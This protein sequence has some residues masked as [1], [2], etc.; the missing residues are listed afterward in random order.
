[1]KLLYKE[2]ALLQSKATADSRGTATT[3]S[4]ANI[5]AEWI[6]AERIRRMKLQ[7]RWK[8]VANDIADLLINYFTK[9]AD[10]LSDQVQNN[11]LSRIKLQISS[12]CNYKIWLPQT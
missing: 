3:K 10:S 7:I 6:M 11:T 4:I 12:L 5:I 2:I 8:S 9:S 1:M